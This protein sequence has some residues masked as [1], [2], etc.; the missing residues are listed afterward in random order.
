MAKF[1]LTIDFLVME[2]FARLYGA[3]S[4]CNLLDKA[5]PEA[6]LDE[7]ASLREIAEEEGWEYGE[8]RA[9]VDGLEAKFRHWLPRFSAYSVIILLYSVLETQL[10][11]YAE[12]VGHAKES[13]FQ[14]KDIHGKGIEQARIF[15]L[16]ASAID[17][18][19]DPLWGQ[20]MDL[21]KLRNFIV[22][23]GGKLSGSKRQ[24]DEVDRLVRSYKGKLDFPEHGELYGFGE[25]WISMPLCRMFGQEVEGFFER[26][27]K[28]GGLPD[29]R[30]VRTIKE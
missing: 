6:E 8:Y 15:L 30:G 17:I 21:H 10:A 13:V 2:T 9:E 27:F 22:H 14:L 23:S 19:S 20:L 18:A 25:I 3:L 16:R 5:I 29:R 24:N 26:L 11:A 1:R 28:A 4:L 7:T 12:R